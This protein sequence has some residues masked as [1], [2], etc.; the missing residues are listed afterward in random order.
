[1]KKFVYDNQGLVRRMYGD[2]RHIFVMQ[3]EL[4][5]EID[6]DDIK[7]SADKYSQTFNKQHN[8][9]KPPNARQAKAKKVA[10]AATETTTTTTKRNAERKNYRSGDASE[11]HFR[12]AQRPSATNTKQR[13]KPPKVNVSEQSSL[14]DNFIQ[15]NVDA[16]DVKVTTKLTSIVPSSSTASTSTTEASEIIHDDTEEVSDRRATVDK[17]VLDLFSNISSALA[18]APT[19]TLNATLADVAVNETSESPPESLKTTLNLTED[20]EDDNDDDIEAEQETTLP[21]AASKDPSVTTTTEAQL[22]Q[23]HA[24]VPTMNR[25]GV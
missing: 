18:A 25:R 10:P 12:P 7:H 9:K 5:N 6:F 17:A 19:T 22:Y 21:A 23:D 13:T 2:Q 14:I 24:I 3:S 15:S 16:L 4:E 20:G 11:P 1:V 8:Q